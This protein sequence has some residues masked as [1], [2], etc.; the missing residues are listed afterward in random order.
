M[1]N[2]TPLQTLALAGLLQT[3]S[4]SQSFASSQSLL[5]AIS[6]FGFL[7]LTQ[8]SQRCLNTGG[9]LV[10]EAVKNLPGCLTGY[11][12][13][14]YR[15]T[16]PDTY[17]INYNN[18]VNSVL[19]QSLNIGQ[20]GTLGIV[21]I[22]RNCY[23]FCVNS[24]RVYGII[25]STQQAELPKNTAGYL[26]KSLTDF[27]TVGVS[28]Q[29]GDLTAPGYKE[30]CDN[31]INFGTMF[32]VSELDSAFTV[33]SMIQSLFRQGFVEDIAKVLNQDNITVANVSAT[34]TTLLISALN[35][36]PKIVVRAILDRTGYHS[37][38][39]KDIKLITEVLDPAVAFGP[40][41]LSLIIDFDN[42]SK[43]SVAVFGQ[44]TTM[45]WVNE[46]GRSLQ[47][48]RPAS[49]NHLTS[50]D[51]SSDSFKQAYSTANLSGLG[52][53][54]GTYGNPTMHD[55]LGSYSGSRYVDL[56]HGL[57]DAQNNV[58]ET[59]EGR[60]VLSALE[61]AHQNSNDISKDSE[62]AASINLA[63]RALLDSRQ[64]SVINGLNTGQDRF[65]RI[66]D[67]LLKEKQNLVDA[68]INLESVQGT[69]NDAVAFV[70]E[71]PALNTDTEQIRYVEFIQAI[72]ADNMYGEA[73]KTVIDEGFNQILLNN[74]GV[75]VKN[76]LTNAQLTG[77]QSGD[78]AQCCP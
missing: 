23:D 24:Y 74:L 11:I 47:S 73:I 57:V 37:G 43:K 2:F 48:I 53:G 27:A 30:L 46:L 40:Q 28:N 51:N 42:L 3:S 50:L 55:M 71:L 16:V 19:Q 61:Q 62:S 45:T 68:G 41:A 67:M 21:K 29:F 35:K 52:Q 6:Q 38:S 18:L 63:T 65:T 25:T 59:T 58:M 76:T 1:E 4:K 75:E 17:G 13:V 64:S 33:Q 39:G 31:L 44:N 5:S 26:Y 77:T 7:P 70:Q 78:S 10:I 9:S 54:N 22:I 20:N 14:N 15:T 69:I 8:A 60:A 66:L 32:D 12:A 36:L 56:I 72:C 49:L 34:Q